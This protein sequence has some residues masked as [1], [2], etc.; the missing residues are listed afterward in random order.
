[1][2]SN[3]DKALS[4]A[5]DNRRAIDVGKAAEEREMLRRRAIARSIAEP[6]LRELAPKVLQKLRELNISP[7]DYL[8]AK[9]VGPFG[10][11][12]RRGHIRWWS[13]GGAS[14]EDYNHG[15]TT[16]CLLENGTFVER[17]PFV[18]GKY[19]VWDGKEPNSVTAPLFRVDQVLAKADSMGSI[20]L[21]TLGGFDSSQIPRVGLCTSCQLIRLSA[22][23]LAPCNQAFTTPSRNSVCISL[24]TSNIN[25]S[26]SIPDR[27]LLV[28]RPFH[29]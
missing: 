27:S 14:S 3:F 13:F 6:Y 12:R 4:E 24:T 16:I 25:M 28:Y 29:A 2:S 21:L 9:P 1:M 19:K 17:A 5:R 18:S 15:A 26:D 8:T 23:S 10:S 7:Q 22:L 11:F 20:Y